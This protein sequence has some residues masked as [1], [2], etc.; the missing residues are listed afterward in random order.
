MAVA[1]KS[2]QLIPGEDPSLDDFDGARRWLAIYEQREALLAARASIEPDALED[3]AAGIRFWSRRVTELSGLD[4]DSDQRVIRGFGDHEIQ[5]TPRE[6]QLL[7]FMLQHPGRF[8]ADHVLAVRAWGERLSG[9]QVR[10]YVR[11]L[12]LKLESTGWQVE[13]RRGQG[14]AL[15]RQ[16]IIAPGRAN[17]RTASAERV[18]QALGRARVLLQV[19]RRQLEVAVGATERLRQHLNGGSPLQS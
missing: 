16:A 2:R 5:L 4:L 1:R 10:I 13:S 18:Q 9:D 12:R 3:I 8:F 7:E 6:L 11:R 15:V 14:Y 19:Q 17:V